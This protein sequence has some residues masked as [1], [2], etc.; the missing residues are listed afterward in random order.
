MCRH[1]NA[2]IS[3]KC[4]IVYVFIYIWRLELKDCLYVNRRYCETSVFT[5]NVIWILLVAFVI[6]LFIYINISHLKGGFIGLV[7]IL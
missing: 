2:V 7:V 4:L 5:V 3:S 6:A 1:L